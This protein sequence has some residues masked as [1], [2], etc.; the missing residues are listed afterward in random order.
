MKIMPPSSKSVEKA[1]LDVALEE[2]A[3]A[4]S[5]GERVDVESYV[6]RLPQ[7][8]NQLRDFVVSMQLLVDFGEVDSAMD[9]KHQTVQHDSVPSSRVLGD[10]RILGELGRGGM[11]VVYEAEQISLDRIVALKILPFAAMLDDRQL[12][13]F[14]NEAR[15]AATLHHPNIVPVF[16]VGSERGVHY[17][18]MQRVDGATLSEVVSDLRA[19]PIAPDKFSEAAPP[20]WE[21]VTTGHVNE[22]QEQPMAGRADHQLE[23]RR[24]LQAELSTRRSRSSVEY[25]RTVTKWG[26]A[27]AEALNYA[28]ENGVL[29]RDIKPGNLMLD[30]A[31]HIWVTDFGLAR[32]E[33]EASM[34]M[35]GDIVG[36]LTYMA[37]EQALAKRVPIDHRADIYSLGATLYELTTTQPAFIGKDRQELLHK[38]AFEEPIRPRKIDSSIPADLETIILKAMSKAPEDRYTSA[39]DVADDLNQFL[40]SRPILAKP[41]TLLDHARKWTKRHQTVT[42]SAVIMLLLTT[43]GLLLGLAWS[44]DKNRQLADAVQ[45]SQQQTAAANQALARESA[46]LAE[47]NT[48]NTKTL[49]ALASAQSAEAQARKHLYLA[50]IRQAYADL[51]Q[52]ESARFAESM[53]R[54]IPGSEAADLRNWEWH[55]L[56]ALYQQQERVLLEHV[57]GVHDL[58]W[59]P[60]GKYLAT[61]GVAGSICLWN[62]DDW[63]LDSVLR[64]N[65]AKAIDWHPDGRFLAIAYTD[66]MIRIWDTKTGLFTH[67]I[68][69]GK[70]DCWTLEFSPDGSQLAGAIQKQGCK[71]WSTNGYSELWHY[72]MANAQGACWSPDG[73]TLACSGKEE[74]GG[75]KDNYAVVI[76]DAMSGSAYG[77]IPGPTGAPPVRWSPRGNRIAAGI[78]NEQIQ[79][80]DAASLSLLH[81][82]AVQAQMEEVKWSHNGRYLAAGI[83]K[84]V[85]I[86][87]AQL[88]RVD[89]L[90]G[91]TG[92]V[93]SIDW[94]ADHKTMVAGA[95]DGATLV[96]QL[97][98]DAS[99]IGARTIC[100][101]LA[102]SGEGRSYFSGTGRFVATLDPPNNEIVVRRVADGEVV[103]RFDVEIID[104]RS[105]TTWSSDDTWLACITHEDR[106]VTLLNVASGECDSLLTLSQGEIREVDWNPLHAQL[107]VSVATDNDSKGRIDIWDTD[108]RQLSSSLP[109]DAAPPRHISW[110][111]K[112]KQLAVVDG[113]SQRHTV[114]QIWD[115]HAS[116]L[117]HT[118][119][120]HIRFYRKPAW[121]PDGQ[122]V[123]AFGWDGGITIWDTDQGSIDKKLHGHSNTVVGVWHPS[124][125]RLLTCSDDKT[126]RLWD[127]E[128]GEEILRIDAH[129]DTPMFTRTGSQLCLAGRSF[130]VI[131]VAG[132]AQAIPLS[133]VTYA[134]SVKV[135]RGELAEADR[136]LQS[137]P[138]GSSEQSYLMRRL[139]NQHYWQATGV[140]A[141]IDHTSPD[142]LEKMLTLWHQLL[143][144]RGSRTHQEY[145]RSEDEYFTILLFQCAN[146]AAIRAER[147]GH[148]PGRML[149]VLADI[150]RSVEERFSDLSLSAEQ[151]V[152]IPKIM[153]AVRGAIKRLAQ[154]T[155]EERA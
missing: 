137:L 43:I 33:S 88:N 58:A 90:K 7:H 98:R 67:E 123:A 144:E 87:D 52:G 104:T 56:L 72:K 66:Q 65:G 1:E 147:N 111:P 28:H 115:V 108:T 38:I 53:V 16:S 47:V 31:S 46:A 86:F 27:T 29:H 73:Q 37:P 14:K 149:S 109:S 63:S 110:D 42:W 92:T 82:V 150:A 13:R 11:G 50:T 36:T 124:G 21:Q 145:G 4:M 120:G 59:H 102:K 134:G 143:E 139:F 116:E 6:T 99:P 146:I 76:L 125:Q 32:I 48:A 45:L 18:A 91:H 70:S 51:Q 64:L 133:L 97:E 142:H 71:I 75:N 130:D 74:G 41:P 103:A 83:G 39:Q 93:L 94:S 8:A 119:T 127:V 22:G 26:L 84:N 54:F 122:R 17:Y 15:A 3:E 95:T 20:S 12:Q 25:F 154:L 141:A 2:I 89:T 5:S 34:T 60:K 69:T 113:N 78:L 24:Q 118:L 107:A 129:Y 57:N 62:P 44:R 105:R 30:R 9:Q 138:D 101:E 96:W 40:A 153:N 55:Y 152:N 23:T 128:S 148:V 49:N 121:S 135:N 112:G 100:P 136:L 77:R 10:F 68:N 35:T 106:S 85:E 126:M 114:L 132:A 19:S 117:R 81:S 79:V 151:K 131:D 155:S 61:A 80:F 140:H